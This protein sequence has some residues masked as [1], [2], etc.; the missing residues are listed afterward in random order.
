MDNFSG[1]EDDN[2]L[3][4]QVLLDMKL[5]APKDM[6][7]YCVRLG[8]SNILSLVLVDTRIEV[9]QGDMMPLFSVIRSSCLECKENK[10]DILKQLLS[11]E[12]AFASHFPMT[13]ITLLATREGNI[14]AL[15]LLLADKRCNVFKN[16]MS[17]LM[18]ALVKD[19]VEAV[20]LVMSCPDFNVAEDDR[21]DILSAINLRRSTDGALDHF[22]S[23]PQMVQ[24]LTR[25]AR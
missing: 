20:R 13:S 15:A 14:Q 11:S 24:L 21:Q 9:Y 4:V 12:R 5:P 23:V 18:T 19:N 3:A 1:I 22:K 7:Q 25:T 16:S 10:Q 6:L 8:L 2:P 17:L